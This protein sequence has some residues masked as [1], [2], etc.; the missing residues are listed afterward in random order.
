MF[1][2]AGVRLSGSQ[3]ARPYQPRLSFSIAFNSDQLFR[4]V[5][6]SIILDRSESTGYGQREHLYHRGATHAGGLPTEYNDL[7][8]IITP[9]RTHTGPAEAQLT[10][11]SD[12][13]LDEQFEKG[14]QGELYEYELVYYP[15]TTD[16]GNPEG[17][18]RPQPDDVVGTSIRYLGAD[19][20]AYRWTYL[21]RNN[22]QQDDYSR[23]MEFTQAM[24]RSGA[25]FDQQIGEYIDVDQWLRAFAFAVITG[26]GDNYSSDGSQHNL[27]LYV[28]PSDNRVLQLVHDLDAFFDATRPLVANGDLTKLIR[29]PERKHMYYGHVQDMIQTTFNEAYMRRWTEYWGSLLPGQRF[30][31]HLSDL[32][33]RS[34]YLIGQIERAAP[35][36][37]FGVNTEDFASATQLATIAGNGWVNV[38]ELRLEGSTT[39]LPVTWTATTAW[40]TQVPVALGHNTFTVQAYDFQGQLVGSDRIAIEG[41]LPN[42]VAASLRISEI[43]YHPFPPTA[44]EL[45][46][47]SGLDQEDFEFLELVNRGSTPIDVLGVHFTDGIEL[48]LPAAQ[49]QPSE[50]AV[51]VRNEAAFRL[52]FGAGPRVIGVYTDSRLNNDGE[53]LTLADAAGVEFFSVDYGDRD[54]WPAG[55]DG[56]GPSLTRTT[57]QDPGDA[58]TDWVAVPPSPGRSA[59]PGDLN[60]DGQVDA[61]DI[62]QLCSLVRAGDSQA[63]LNGD[64]Q[65]DTADVG[66]FV[67]VVLDT[68]AGDADV[69]GIFDSSDMIRVFVVG[70][71]EDGIPGNSGWGDGDWDCDG[72]FN[73]NDIVL[74]FQEGGYVAA[75]RPSTSRMEPAATDL[76]DSLRLPARRLQM[77]PRRVTSSCRP[78]PQ[79]AADVELLARDLIFE[80]YQGPSPVEL[81]D[82]APILDLALG[83][84]ATLR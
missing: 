73:T 77:A 18:K 33:R 42:P 11:Y 58:P 82:E 80:Q 48:T 37:D 10:R 8:Y 5:H 65:L 13:Y 6:S 32:V 39:P 57:L 15:T 62:D 20:E 50:A 61:H 54:P 55:A 63:D 30:D 81:P 44:S 47:N 45:V 67:H 75:S 12:V 59:A 27:E 25:T 78:T 36:V 49:L 17:R 52:R 34:N 28:R 83:I 60:A 79:H 29:V 16:N 56:A 35:R 84:A 38:R 64:G 74:A 4:G 1:Y 14:S 53:Q 22:R 7:L 72:E 26:H 31:T 43:Y 19:Q 51:V 21:I 76:A 41:T 70:E 40:Q 66:Y 24:G 71:Y 2:D 69:D 3:R 9:Q 68:H 46:A 23:L